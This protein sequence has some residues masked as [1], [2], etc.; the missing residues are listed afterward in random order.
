MIDQRQKRLD[1]KLG[2]EGEV[3]VKKYLRKLYPKSEGYKVRTFAWY[4][5]PFDIAIWKDG[6]IV[7][8]YEVKNRNADIDTYPSLMFSKSK[9]DYLRNKIKTGEGKD[10]TFLWLLNNNK[11]ATWD[12]I[13]DKEQYYYDK[14]INA[15]R[16]DTSK[17]CVYVWTKYIT[18]K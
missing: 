17:D 11:I 3:F 16:N 18:C 15:K 10:F 1:K 4:Y 14:G 7:K 8:E 13:D 6:K 2:N 12:Y 9:L 5:A